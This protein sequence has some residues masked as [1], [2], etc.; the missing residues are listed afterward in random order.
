MKISILLLLLVVAGCKSSPKELPA[1]TDI[2]TAATGF[3]SADSTALVTI[4][5]D[6]F[7]AFDEKDIEKMSSILGPAITIIHHNGATTNREEM[8][9]IIKET[10]NWWP[11]TRTLSNFECIADTG[12]AIVGCDNE[13]IFSL[14]ENKKS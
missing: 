2:H 14:P 4:V 9:A 3:T 5:K 7:K 12:I 10:K 1:K 6:F 8:L 11:R 13:V